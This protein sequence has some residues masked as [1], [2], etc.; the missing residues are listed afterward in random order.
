MSNGDFTSPS[1]GE[2]DPALWAGTGEGVIPVRKALTRFSGFPPSNHPLPEKGEGKRHSD[3]ELI[4]E[5]ER[6]TEIPPTGID[7]FAGEY[8]MRHPAQR[9]V[10]PTGAPTPSSPLLPARYH[11]ATMGTGV[12]EMSRLSRAVAVNGLWAVAV[13]LLIS[14]DTKPKDPIDEIKALIPKLQ[15]RLNRRDVGGL[16]GMGT[17]RFESNSLVIAVFGDRARDSVDLTLKRINQVGKDATLILSVRF[18]GD[19]TTPVRELRLPLVAGRKWW[20]DG[21]EFA[22]LVTPLDTS[23]G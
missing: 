7:G 22:P 19:V 5:C 17:D 18:R 1:K 15:Q 11:H 10:R 21:F 8:L 13:L 9:E 4:V 2:V 14:C 6:A 12:I 16:K 3:M 23:R 20:I